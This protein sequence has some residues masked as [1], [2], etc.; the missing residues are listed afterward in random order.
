MSYI[1]VRDDI[2]LYEYW[3]LLAIACGNEEQE[4]FNFA[5]LVAIAVNDPKKIKRLKPA[6]IETATKPTDFLVGM[7]AAMGNTK[8]TGSASEFARATGRRIIYATPAGY[9][10]ENGQPVMRERNDLVL[11][12]PQGIQ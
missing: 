12:Q 2:D 10:D 5:N 3:K 4:D 1:Q 6:S 9:I 11:M 8:P 7:V